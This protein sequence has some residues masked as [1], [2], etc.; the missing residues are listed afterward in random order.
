M[1]LSIKTCCRKGTNPGNSFSYN[2]PAQGSA[3][4]KNSRSFFCVMILV[5]IYCHLWP[6]F[7]ECE[8]YFR[9][10][11]EKKALGWIFRKC[12]RCKIIYSASAN[13]KLTYAG[14]SLEN[15]LPC[16]EPLGQTPRAPERKR[17]AKRP[18]TRQNSWLFVSSSFPIVSNDVM[19]SGQTLNG[20]FVKPLQ[21]KKHWLY[22]REKELWSI[23][24]YVP[25]CLLRTYSCSSSWAALHHRNLG[26]GS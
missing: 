1:R 18:L 12:N 22:L 5:W 14:F 13:S 15:I 8:A 4:K 21:L 7:E 9:S 17:F 19:V 11:C 26:T 3:S 25:A 2:F 10:G 16:K 23:Q 6:Q 20:N 24:T